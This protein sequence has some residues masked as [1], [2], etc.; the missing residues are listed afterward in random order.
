MMTSRA[1]WALV[2]LLL[3]IVTSMNRPS[4]AAPGVDADHDGLPDAWETS[5]GRAFGCDPRHADLLV[6]AVERTTMTA[7]VNETIAKAT[8]FFDG[9]QVTNPDGRRGIHLR[10]IRGPKTTRPE[11]YQDLMKVYLPPALRGRA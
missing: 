2:G 4:N 10:V 11:S 3:I 9:L 8:A 5:A 1:H 6:Y 7:K